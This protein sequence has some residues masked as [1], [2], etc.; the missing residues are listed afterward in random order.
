MNM[1]SNNFLWDM[2]LKKRIKLTRCRDRSQHLREQA[3]LKDAAEATQPQ[4]LSAATGV[5]GDGRL[6]Q[7]VRTTEALASYA[8]SSD[9]SLTRIL[10]RLS[11]PISGVLDRSEWVASHE[12]ILRAKESL[13]AGDYALNDMPT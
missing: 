8:V 10:E 1:Y 12:G 5:I 9:G 2:T 11:A 6:T 4:H 3:L 13:L 7:S